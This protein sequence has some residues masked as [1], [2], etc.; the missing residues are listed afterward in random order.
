MTNILMHGCNGAMGRVISEL[1]Q[2]DE[3]SKIVAGVDVQTTKHFQYPVFSGLEQVDVDYDVIID[4]SNAKAVDALLAYVKAKQKPLVLC[5]TGLCGEQLSMIAE[6]KK[7]TAILRSANMSLGINLMMK[8]VK[9]AA[10]V[11]YPSDFDVEIVEKH[12]RRKLDAPSGTALAL[13]DSINEE[14]QERL[15]YVYERQSVHEKRGQHQLGIS[16]V[17]GGTIVGEHEVLFCGE[18]EIITISHTALSR[19]IFAK[20]AISAAKYLKGKRSGLYTMAD[21]IDGN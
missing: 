3:Q 9:M 21:V 6:C 14:L 11:L 1:L 17:R 18:D 16:V 8:L 20:G 19:K 5:T 2:E 13:A 4:F 10:S 15:Q 7:K 12:H